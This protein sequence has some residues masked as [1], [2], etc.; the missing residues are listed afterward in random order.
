MGEMG[1]L[2]ECN[3]DFFLEDIFDTPTY[4]EVYRLAALKIC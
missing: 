3:A 4:A 2:R 1:L